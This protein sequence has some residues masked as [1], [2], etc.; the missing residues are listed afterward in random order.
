MRFPPYLSPD[1][2]GFDELPASAKTLYLLVQAKPYRSL[3]QLRQDVGVSEETIRRLIR[4]LRKHKW[5]K[6]VRAGRNAVPIPVIPRNEDQRRAALLQACYKACQY[7]GEFQLREILDAC[8]FMEGALYNARPGFLTSPLSDEKLEY[9]VF[10]PVTMDAWE[11]HGFQHFGPTDV[12]SSPEKAR[13]QQANDLIKLGR[14][15]NEGVNVVVLTYKDLSIDGILKTLPAGVPR[16]PI[17][18]SSRYIR[19][20]ERLASDYRQ[21]AAGTEKKL[22]AK[23][24]AAARAGAGNV[25]ATESDWVTTEELELGMG[26]PAEDPRR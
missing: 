1:M 3:A 11:L 25:A 16:R 21:W 15:M 26:V 20:L 9:D 18:R 6:L 24:Q 7:K 12:F 19:T 10:N 14:S 8:A 2:D 23:R 17:D 4:A 13:L 22:L 5:V